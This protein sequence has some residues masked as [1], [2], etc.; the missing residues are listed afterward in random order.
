[1]EQLMKHLWRLE[2]AFMK[3]LLAAYPEPKPA[4]TTVATLI[5]RLLDRQFVGYDQ[6][7]AVREYFPKVSRRSYFTT[8]LK[9]MVQQ[10][11]NGSNGQFA[12]FFAENLDLSEVELQRLKELVNQQLED[13]KP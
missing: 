6:R 2:R 8:L 12:S 1:E 10:F 11:F 9:G 13:R 7:G 4:K 5:K 3:D